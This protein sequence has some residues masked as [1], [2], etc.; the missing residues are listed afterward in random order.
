ML[1]MIYVSDKR[2]T[3]R[4][5]KVAKN[6]KK[7]SK[8]EQTKIIQMLM[9]DPSQFFKKFIFLKSARSRRHFRKN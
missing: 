8:K 9:M 5:E 7:L 1:H 4:L 6:A 3:E 2:R